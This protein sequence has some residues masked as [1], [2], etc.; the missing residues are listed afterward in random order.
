[1]VNHKDAAECTEL[2]ELLQALVGGPIQCSFSP[3][4]MNPDAILLEYLNRAINSGARVI[5]VPHSLLA[6][7]SPEALEEARRLCALCGVEV[8][9][10]PG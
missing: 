8:Y 1:V 5:E 10:V 6:A 4:T 2:Y 3:A 7:A 9:A